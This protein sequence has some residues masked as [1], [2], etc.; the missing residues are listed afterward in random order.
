MKNAIII[1]ILSTICFTTLTFKATEEKG[2][3]GTISGYSRRSDSAA[4]SSR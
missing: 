4:D 3:R 2:R 1:L